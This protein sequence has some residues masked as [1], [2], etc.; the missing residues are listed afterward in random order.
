[1]PENHNQYQA[2][3]VSLRKEIKKHG[4]SGY[5]LPR[6]D[7]FQSEFLAPYAERLKWL[8]AFTG[9]AAS[10]IILEGVAVVLS[11]SRYTIQL[12]QEVPGDLYQTENIMDVSVGDW[13]FEH[14]P[15]GA[16]VGYDMW[17]YTPKQIDAIREKL[18]E[19]DV[20]L[21]PLQVNL[22]DQIWLNQPDKP[23]E[24]VILFP[25]QVAGM[26]S[27]EKRREISTLIKEAGCK[28][29]L[30]TVSDSICWLLNVRGNDIGY[31]PL[32]LSYVLLYEDATVDW[33]VDLDKLS[34]DVLN[35]LGD[36]IR[37]VDLNEMETHIESVRSSKIWT[38][39]ASCPVWFTHHLNDIY[40]QKDPCITPKSIKTT[41]E[42]SAI[43]ETH[44]HDG[45]ALVR[46]LK[47]LDD[48]AC[49]EQLSELSVERKLE[50]FRALHPS[51]IRTSFPTIAGFGAHGAIVHYRANEQSNRMI[52]EGGLLL[53]D[54]GGQY[55]WGTTDITRTVSI[56]EPTL[57]M[58][59]N[60]TRVLKGHIALACAQFKK[61]TIGK[62]VDPL[63][64][65]SLK[66]VGL[67]YGHGTGHGVGCYLC[68]H[69]DA[70]NISPRG[71]VAFENGMLISNEP[72]YYKE[73]EY[74][75]RIENLV[76]VQ[77]D[78]VN[79]MLYFDTVSLA[80]LDKDLIAEDMLTNLE[81]QWLSAYHSDI[82]EK[83]SPYLSEDERGW[84]ENQKL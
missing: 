69:E 61:G 59:E 64:R 81:I 34:P 50:E 26:S 15:E 38:D 58:K 22:I 65:A 68:V 73:G 29:C 14:A 51:Y 33:F 17:L 41:E 25:Q 7:E 70:A 43:R 46:F 28:A 72:G 77:E 62:D 6:T 30:L 20:E 39:R 2:R 82:L 10:A 16:K 1:M 60:Y 31:S 27:L 19:R 18:E 5:I 63:A 44:I 55:H 11:D 23:Q 56:G 24:S 9:S 47:W 53:V 52:E 8:T 79:G 74:G 40:D 67:D 37:I 54:S 48:V 80:P 76:L 36:D 42:Q 12:K 83:L 71:E 35:A 57:E 45:V 3:L 13:L 32:V 21:I 4:L 75:I 78:T 84:L 66:E 49:N